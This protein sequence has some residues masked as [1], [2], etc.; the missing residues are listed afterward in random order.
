LEKL[1][2]IIRLL[3]PKY[4]N[5]ITYV[6]V[7]C[8]TS[9]L[10][11][12][13]W[14]ELLN[15]FF[16]TNN[17]NNTDFQFSIVGEWD[18]LLGLI[19]IIIGLIYNTRN[20]LIDLKSEPKSQPEYKNVGILKYKSFEKICQVI[21]PILKD[22]EYVFKTVGPNSGADVQEELRTDFTMWYKYR[23]ETII[24][25][26][27]KIKDIL[28]ANTS[29]YDRETEALVNQM[30]LHIDAFEE[31]I[32]NEDFDYSAYQ[33]PIEF[34]N[35]V[36]NNCLNYAETSKV[37]LARQKWLNKKIKKIQPNEWYIF[38]SSIFIPEKAKDVDIVLFFEHKNNKVVQSK[39]KVL[40]M[41]FK[42]KFSCNLHDTIF[43]Q[44]EQEQYQNF[45][46][47]N[48]YKIK[49]NG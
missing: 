13:L 12:P 9:L 36:E 46:D 45:I 22:N 31:H 10:T 38:G 28:N 30:T 26:N 40:K 33:F 44:N 41:D 1:E 35:L 6:L 19:V 37:F 34:K 27:Q 15:F 20:R 29:I 39:M 3:K 18:W 4:Y 11:K 23:S 49:G 24:P 5:R 16:E 32:R 7:I 42:L 43:Y 48:E 14:L 25:N 17:E 2:K 21:Y 47:Y 8:G